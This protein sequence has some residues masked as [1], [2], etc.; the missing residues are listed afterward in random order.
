[1]IMCTI[2]GN[3][4]KDAESRTVGQGKIVLNFSVAA[5]SAGKNSETVWF[6][7]AVWG[8]RGA[9]IREYIV[10]GTKVTAVGSLSK[11]ESNGKTYL[12][13][14]VQDIDFSS[15][16]SDGGTPRGSSNDDV[17]DWLRDA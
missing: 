16:K 7:C 10:K 13:L 2:T 12:K 6:D 8:E 15:P 9:K 4:G 3:V 1:M 5:K 17:P 14:D 11:H